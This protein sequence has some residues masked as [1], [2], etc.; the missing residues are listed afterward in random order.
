MHGTS[1]IAAFRPRRSET[2]P[3]AMGPRELPG[4]FWTITQML[5]ETAQ[6]PG[7]N[8]VLRDR[9]SPGNVERRDSGSEHE[10]DV[11]GGTLEQPECRKPDTG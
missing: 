5:Q 8:D 11:L 10:R 4:R 9:G 1:I 3:T 6:S 2:A 7:V